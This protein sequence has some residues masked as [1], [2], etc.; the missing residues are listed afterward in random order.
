MRT[1]RLFDSTMHSDTLCSA[2]TI[3]AS[4]QNPYYLALSN[5]LVFRWSVS[6]VAHVLAETFPKVGGWILDHC[7]LSSVR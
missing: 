3:L 4:A 5:P 7:V 6:L 1:A 2:S